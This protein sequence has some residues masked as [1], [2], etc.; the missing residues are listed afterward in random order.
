MTSKP[1]ALCPRTEWFPEKSS[2]AHWCGGCLPTNQENSSSPFHNG[3]RGR[4]KPFLSSRSPLPAKFGPFEPRPGCL[5]SPPPIS[6]W[7][8]QSRRKD[9]DKSG[10]IPQHFPNWY[11]FS[12]SLLLVKCRGRQNLQRSWHDKENNP[13]ASVFRWLICIW[14]PN[15]LMMGRC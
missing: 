1:L 10:L 5:S 2:C 9:Y 3:W 12:W 4:N 6:C 13:R 11:W 8:R 7:E 14:E 15:P